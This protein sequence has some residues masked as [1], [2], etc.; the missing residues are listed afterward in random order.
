M[1]PPKLTNTFPAR[2][3]RWA[4]PLAGAAVMAAALLVY[5][6]ARDNAFVSWDDNMYVTDNPRVQHATWENIGWFFTHPYFRSYTP[7]ALVS[8]AVDYSLWGE[9]PRG[10]HIHNILLHSLNAGWVY[11]LGLLIILRIRQTPPGEH[12]QGFV[13]ILASA[14]TSAILGAAIG[15]LLFAL[16]PLRVESVAW[17]S[18]RKDLLCAFFLLPSLIC[19][20]EYRLSTVPRIRRRWYALSLMLYV[21]ALLSKSI[22]TTIPIVILILDFVLE[23]GSVW[24]TR[25]RLA[26][27]D[28][29]PFLLLALAITAAA[30]GSI[31]DGGATQMAAEMSTSQKAFLPF[32]SMTFYLG[33]LLLPSNLAPVYDLPSSGAMAVYALLMVLVTLFFVI[34][35]RLFTRY[36][37]MAWVSYVVIVAPTVFFLSSGIQP[38]AD[39]YTYLATLSFFLLAGGMIA[40]WWR[41]KAHGRRGQQVRVTLVAAVVLVLTMIAL[42]SYRQIRIWQTSITLWSHAVRISP[43]VAAAYNGLGAAMG[44]NQRTDEAVAL[45]EEALRLQ[46]R[47]ALAWNNL[48]IV[49]VIRGEAASA[50]HCFRKAAE[51]SPEYLEPYLQLGVLAESAGEQKAALEYFRKARTIDPHSSLAH[52]GLAGLFA[53]TGMSDS[54]VVSLQRAQRDGGADAMI[55]AKAGAIYERI[56]DTSAANAAFSRAARL[57]NPEARKTLKERRIQW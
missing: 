39:R 11:F 22:A 29:V 20:V 44:Q 50:A 54:C 31:P 15:A 38:V 8:H 41:V 16:H 45:F 10:H 19:Y 12:R 52:V 26:L 37:L 27:K 25:K 47:Y 55:Y 43:G 14:D 51:N 56:G 46:P 21:P 18:D 3:R 28:K 17:V 36:G 30:V 57:G 6:P 42:L 32:Y 23:G 2:I 24:Q 53:A 5:S 49:Y 34:V 13:A 48:G 35:A 33:K 4:V 40:Q 7:L 9:D 1:A